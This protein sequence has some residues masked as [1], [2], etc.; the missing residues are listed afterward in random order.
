M[1]SGLRRSRMHDE[2]RA[3]SPS[4]F[5]TPR[6]RST[7]ASDESCPPSNP[8]LNFLR[9]TDGRSN[10][11]RVSSL[12][13]DVA[14]LIRSMSEDTLL[15]FDLPSVARKKLSVGFDGGQLSSDA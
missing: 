14:L 4:F 9:A 10:G 12:M 1:R 7:P 3:A 8:T 6:S 2:R 11:R 13:T 5:S 15:P